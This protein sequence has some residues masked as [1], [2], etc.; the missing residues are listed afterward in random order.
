MRQQGWGRRL[1]MFVLCLALGMT[2]SRPASATVDLTGIWVIATDLVGTFEATLTQTGSMLG[3][4]PGGFTGTVDS[5]TGAFSLTGA[6]YP[7]GVLPNGVPYGPSP[8]TAITGIPSADGATFD[9]TYVTWIIKVT[10]PVDFTHF[11]WFG[12]A[13]P[14]HGVHSAPLLLSAARVH[15]GTARDRVIVDGSIDETAVK[16]GFTSVTVITGSPTASRS[17]SVSCSPR[18]ARTRRCVDGSGHLT[19]FLFRRH[20][21]TNWRLR[22]VARQ[23]SFGGPVGGPVGLTLTDGAGQVWKDE[24]STCTL[25]SFSLLRCR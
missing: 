25:A 21:E 10:P 14:I 22:V 5:T 2:V 15:L 12:F 7:G 1:S 23:L 18:R 19:I 20:P 24:I 3:W 4:E 8:P 16:A 6:S 9:G 11:P 13:L 17:W